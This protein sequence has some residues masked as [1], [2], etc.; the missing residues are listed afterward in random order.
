MERKSAFFSRAKVFTATKLT[1]RVIKS[2]QEVITANMAFIIMLP[3]VV[4]SI[5]YN[6]FNA[7]VCKIP[8]TR[9]SLYFIVKRMFGSAN[10]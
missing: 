5:L 7:H 9:I 3:G 6:I 4:C 1:I 2:K 10:I 8:N